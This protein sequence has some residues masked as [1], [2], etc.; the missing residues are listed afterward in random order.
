MP[1][2]SLRGERQQTR[3]GPC[4]EAACRHQS[5]WLK[6]P[7]V[8]A[9]P[10][11]YQ[12]VVSSLL[13]GAING[14]SLVPSKQLLPAKCRLSPQRGC[15]GLGTASMHILLRLFARHGRA[16]QENL[17]ETR[18][19]RELTKRTL[20]SSSIFSRH[21]RLLG[22]IRAPKPLDLSRG[23]TSGKVA[24]KV[25]CDSRNFVCFCVRMVRVGL[26]PSVFLPD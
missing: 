12:S 2:L 3:P 10:V 7:G 15:V 6:C 18:A 24:Q 26:K 19:P 5:T 13:Q 9:R 1:T 14:N 4:A 20:H 25:R 21:T 11:G 16:V 17:G 22:A 8:I 23:I